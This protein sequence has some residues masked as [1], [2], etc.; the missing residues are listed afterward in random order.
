MSTQAAETPAKAPT[1]SAA[2]PLPDLILRDWHFS[3]DVEGIAWAVIDREGE[4]TNT[5]GR[6]V[7][8]ELGTIVDRVEAIAKSD[9]DAAKA[10]AKDKSAPAASKGPAPG[11]LQGLVFISGKTSGFI[12]GADVREFEAVTTEKEIVEAVTQVNGLFDRIE[13]LRVPVVAAIDGFC[14]GGGL[15]LA[16]ACHWRIATRTDN[17]RLG[18]PEV[19]LGIFP[20]F[21]GTARS[22]KYAGPINAMQ[23]MLTGAMLRPTVA[24][25]QG[26]LNELVDSRPALRWAARR[27]VLRKRRAEGASFSQNVLR[28]WPTRGFVAKQIR[29]KTLEKARPDHY[30]APFALIEHFEKNGG[31]IARLKREETKAFA[32]LLLSDTSKNLRRVFHLM[33]T[34]KA[35]APKDG[36]APQR[37][38][39]IGAGTMGADIAAW[40]VLSG[41]EASLQ[42][43]SADA[44]KSALER[45]KK[46]F[47]RRY[48]KRAEADAAIARLV[49][50]PK[51]D[52]IGRADVVIEAIVEKLEAKQS[53]FKSLEPKLKPGAV[54][55]T[56]TSSIPLE[57]IAKP[58]ADPGRLIG[59]HFF[60]PVSLM[61]LVEIVR[62]AS[63]R[64]AEIKKGCTFV[65]TIGK[66]PLIVKSAPGFLVNRVLGPYLDAAMDRLDGG[67]KR[68]VIDE[69]AKAFGMPMGPLEVADTVG[70][71]ICAHVAETLGLTADPA[72]GKRLRALIDAKKLGKKSGE[73]FYVWKDGK[74]QREPVS[75]SDAELKK[76]GE[77][78]VQPLIAECEK[79]LAEGIVESADMADA[80]VIF[81][82]GFAPFRG[83]PLHYSRNKGAASSATPVMA[84]KAAA[85]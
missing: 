29:A 85:E 40:A 19:R 52:H 25:T 10:R 27:A 47:R 83:G 46:Q 23:G 72:K 67:T 8:E 75:V 30:P 65:T 4:S 55:A 70:L 16:L 54:L 71:D 42:D 62:S 39:V 34:M 20:G 11:T 2:F 56:N 64:D 35:Q 81:G 79:C 9:A 53:L 31:S 32:P 63:S 17:T 24:R 37:V 13:A 84:A 12:A 78:L 59:V 1:P 43:L 60:N 74:A 5:L 51:G 57:E 21:N 76:L 33:E 26:L 77:E 73:G 3:I 49:A 45:A 44:I 82:S 38:H 68:D 61:P 15:E 6:R 22:I 14:L 36:I 66:L 80:G 28:K 7:L 69:A 41:M 58:L 48:K 18:F 50:D